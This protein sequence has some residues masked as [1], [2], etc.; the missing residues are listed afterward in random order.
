M[1]ELLLQQNNSSQ[2][3]NNI[4]MT[5]VFR[6]RY[7]KSFAELENVKKL[8]LRNNF[9]VNSI[10][11]WVDTATGRTRYVLTLLASIR[12]RDSHLILNCHDFVSSYLCHILFHGRYPLIQTVHAKGGVVREAFND[13]PSLIGSFWGKIAK[14]VEWTSISKADVVTFTSNGSRQL[15]EEQHPGLLNNKDVRVIYAGVDLNELASIPIDRDVRK[16]YAIPENAFLFVSVAALVSDKGL[17]NLIEAIA[18]LPSEIRSNV[19]CLIVGRDGPLR[20]KLESTIIEKGLQ[21]TVLLVG[22][23]ERSDLVNLMREAT[24]FVLTP[25]VS[26]FDH[27]LLEVGALGTPIITTAVGG[28]LEMFDAESAI[29]IPPGD[30]RA[31]VSAL[32]DILKD[33]ERRKRLG[34]NVQKRIR[35]LF[36][37]RTLYNSFQN[38]Y[39][40]LDKKGELGKLST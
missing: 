36:T 4:P 24:A 31:L 20:K 6:E 34:M 19:R 9:K 26:V 1:M 13:N 25:R 11:Y 30:S 23:M 38:L 22:F 21:N 14:H 32:L 28:N 39:L 3:E 18:L 33:D 40:E 2:N 7:F 35:S 10:P 17:E 16:K 12:G 27:V 5:V 15:F 29:L 37:V 8:P